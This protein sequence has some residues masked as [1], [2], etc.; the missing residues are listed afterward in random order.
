MV[1][2]GAEQHLQRGHE[3]AGVHQFL[4][5][6]GAQGCQGQGEGAHER[7]VGAGGPLRGD[8]VRGVGRIE[9]AE[10]LFVSPKTVEANLARVYRKLGVGS[11]AQLA[12]VV[13]SRREAPS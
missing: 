7:L 3:Q 4:F 11:K 9:I 5:D 10:A 6:L 2:G 1:V 12:S 8:E 13:A